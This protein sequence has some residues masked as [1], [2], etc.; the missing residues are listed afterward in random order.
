MRNIMIDKLIFRTSALLYADNNYDVKPDRILV[1]II[2]SY[3]LETENNSTFIDTLISG[4]KKKFNFDF[5]HDEIL[6]LITHTNGKFIVKHIADEILEV[7][8]ETQRYNHLKEKMSK[9]SV[10]NYIEDFISNNNLHPRFKQSIYKFLYF[11]INNN[12]KNFHKL[13]KSNADITK[14]LS[15]DLNAR[16]SD[17]ERLIINRFLVDDNPNKNKAIYDIICYSLEYCLITGDGKT[18][19]EHGLKNKNLYL[20]TNI[21]FRAIGINGDFR[22]KRT[23]RFLSKCIS[24]GQN[25]FISKYTDDEFKNTIEDKIC[26]VIDHHTLS[27]KS[28]IIFWKY[29]ENYDINSYYIE[30]SSKV[31]NPNP[32]LFKAHIF[33]EYKKMLRK[34][35]IT[36]NYKVLE[37]GDEPLINQYTTELYTYKHK[38]CK[39]DAKNIVLLRKLR[40]KKK[41]HHNKILETPYFII[42]TDYKIMNYCMDMF[43]DE[44]PICL[45]PSYWHTILLK[46]T[47]RTDDDYKSYVSFLQL[48]SHEKEINDN[49]KLISVLSGIDDLIENPDL[50]EYYAIE[51]LEN[52]VNKIINEDDLQLLHDKTIS[53]VFEDLKG[54]YSSLEEELKNVNDIKQKTDDDLEKE[55]REKED[56]IAQKLNFKSKLDQTN[57]KIEK[58]CETNANIEVKRI[59][60]K[61]VIGYFFYC[62]FLVFWICN[63]IFFNDKLFGVIDTYIRDCKSPTL[64]AFYSSFLGVIWAIFSGYMFYFFKTDQREARRLKYYNKEKQKVAL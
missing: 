19:Y 53:F 48:Q 2:E 35:K 39:T 15:N 34:Y 64:Q 43:N 7:K 63:I 17:D 29:A 13:V 45:L 59:H 31:K 14:L 51:I 46:Y 1:K 50:I 41:A 9:Y 10:E 20:D 54:K 38:N 49:D 62:A 44:T 21:I 36:I 40:D 24:S 55:I 60:K 12:I 42:S 26:N 52:G 57:E 18:I 8:L 16:F 33:A 11:V 58:L 5:N 32:S 3:F 37:T 25:L 22:K 28:S 4:I 61:I 56:E 23:Q 27:K 47:S 6:K 30:W